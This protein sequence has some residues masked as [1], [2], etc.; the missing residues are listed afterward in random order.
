MKILALTPA[1]PWP[2]HTGGTRRSAAILEGLAARHQVALF[3]LEGEGGSIQATAGAPL[4]AH[5]TVPYPGLPARGRIRFWTQV[6]TDPL[7]K[8]VRQA[9]NDD[10]L[11][12]AAAFA[13]SFA[14]DAI[15]AEPIEMEPYLR[16]CAD[17]VPSA[18][19]MLGWIDVV[20][21]NLRR[22][23]ARDRGA[24][25]RVHA[26]REIA[27]MTR[28]ERRAAARVDARTC[29]SPADRDALEALTGRP[30]VVA[31]NGVDA[32]LFTPRPGAVND[33]QLL[34]VGPLSF[35][36]N[37]DAVTW[38]ASQILPKLGGVT[39]TVA[40]EPAG[41]AAP[42][43][44][45]L[46]GRVQDV[47]HMTARAGAVV[48]PLRS[49]SGT[50]LKILEALAMGKAVVSTRIG[51]EGLDVEHDRD[52]LIADDADA[53]AAAVR[54]VL[55]D[56]ALRARLGANGRALVQRR[57]RWEDTVKAVESALAGEGA[58]V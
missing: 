51:A 28:L 39:L 40:G 17:A 6:L 4:A 43:G 41:F 21:R 34:F 1:L 5:A 52:L 55:G 32:T 38:F 10:T 36:P 57:Y 35:P 19:T 46:A 30:F 48:V 13:R 18:R 37:R 49:G 27:R 11:A 8:A 25:H 47:R 42:A 45:G 23:T 15:Y 56:A 26:H 33:R 58:R 3:A 53:F 54:R 24:A 9:F 50:R 20:S 14:P 12:A 29:V 44:V 2:P 31:P 22:Q 7:P 16:A